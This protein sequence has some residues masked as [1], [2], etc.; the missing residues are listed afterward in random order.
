MAGY[1]TGFE[2]IANDGET[3]S[4]ANLN[5]PSTTTSNCGPIGVSGTTLTCVIANAP[6]QVNGRTITLTR[7]AATGAWTCDS[8][9]A[10]DAKTKYSPKSCQG[11]AAPATP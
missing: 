9:L 7:A 3:P 6:S 4:V 2:L 1:K 8:D 10:G 11:A 5:I